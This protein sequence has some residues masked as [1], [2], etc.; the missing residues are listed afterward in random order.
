MA[1]MITEK[2]SAAADAGGLQRGQPAGDQQNGGHQPLTQPP[3]GAVQHGRILIADGEQ[4]RD[5]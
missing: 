1:S 4:G 2:G 3:D 5:H